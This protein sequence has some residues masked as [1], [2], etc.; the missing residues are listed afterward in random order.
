M[1]WVNDRTSQSPQVQITTGS[2]KLDHLLK[3]G[4]ETG[5]IT[6]AGFGNR[7]C[8]R[9]D[10]PSFWAVKKGWEVE[11]KDFFFLL[12]QEALLHSGQLQN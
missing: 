10:D 11:M 7:K 3:G 6:E 8:P 1:S 2:A 4:V 5:Q 9:M 12:K